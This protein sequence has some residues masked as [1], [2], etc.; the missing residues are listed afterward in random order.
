MAPRTTLESITRGKAFVI[1]TRLLRPGK[2]LRRIGDFVQGAQGVVN[3]IIEVEDLLDGGGAWPGSAVAG[4]EASGA[5]GDG[6]VGLQFRVLER[7]EKLGRLGSEIV[8]QPPLARQHGEG[9]LLPRKF[10]KT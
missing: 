3:F 1:Q 4:V 5:G 2:G 8:K 9:D 6:R 7:G 10:P